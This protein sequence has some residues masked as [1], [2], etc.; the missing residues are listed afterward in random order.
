[1]NESTGERN[2]FMVKSSIQAELMFA[3]ELLLLISVNKV[4]T[5]RRI[6]PYQSVR[7]I[8]QVKH[9]TLPPPLHG[10]QG[11]AS[12]GRKASILMKA[13]DFNKSVGKTTTPP[14]K[15]H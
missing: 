3:C 14:K 9:K 10:G 15:F 1:M 6:S 13:S 12:Y 11:F 4:Y 5:C 7:H 2:G 8:R